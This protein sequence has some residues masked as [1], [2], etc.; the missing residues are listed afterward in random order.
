MSYPRLMLII[1]KINVDYVFSA[2]GLCVFQTVFGVNGQDFHADGHE[3]G[4]WGT[5][6]LD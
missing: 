3:M 1:S 6:K 4:L 5:Q 2:Q